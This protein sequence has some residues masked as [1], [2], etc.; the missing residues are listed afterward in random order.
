MLYS[1]FVGTLNYH[2]KAIEVSWQR[3]FPKTK[4]DGLERQRQ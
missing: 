4:K 1:A 2:H 3:A